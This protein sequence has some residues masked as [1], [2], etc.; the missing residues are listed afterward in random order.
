MEGTITSAEV[1]RF[2]GELRLSSIASKR[3]RLR[4]RWMD[5]GMIAGGALLL[6]LTPATNLSDGAKTDSYVV[7]GVIAGVGVLGF[8]LSFIKSDGEKAW[9]SY[10]RGDPPP[11]GKRRWRASPQAGRGYAGVH[12]EGTF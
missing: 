2:E 10:S 11:V 7:G 12:L 9:E 6:G 1:A 5:V 3:M 8:G 4:E